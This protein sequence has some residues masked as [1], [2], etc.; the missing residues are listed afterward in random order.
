MNKELFARIWYASIALQIFVAIPVRT[1]LSWQ[2]VNGEFSEPIARAFNTYCY[3]TVVSNLL[4]GVVCVFLA[5][6]KPPTSDRFV[7]AQ[8]TGLVC[9]IV[10]GT[11]YHLL[12]A[13]EDQLQ[14]AAVITNLVV[15]TTAPI[16][17]TIGWLFFNDHGRTTW[18]TVKFSLIF[19]IGWAIFAM[20]RGAI[21]DYYP[22]PFMDV[23]YLG[24]LHALIN[25]AVVTLFFLG[26]FAGAHLL[27]QRLPSSHK[28]TDH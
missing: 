26:L 27:D 17:F 3:F 8:L 13:S 21:I 20:I 24:Y 19:P 25:M 1:V 6:K 28:S 12:L 22:Y 23:N 16:M 7:I 10:A 11:V 4:V 14:G 9:I 18:R 5:K 15:H 2:D